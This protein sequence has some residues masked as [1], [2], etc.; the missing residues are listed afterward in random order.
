MEPI[1]DKIHRQEA[2]R[3]KEQACGD[4]SNLVRPVG[5]KPRKKGTRIGIDVEVNRRRGTQCPK[6]GSFLCV[7]REEFETLLQ[8]QPEGCNVGLCSSCGYNIYGKPFA[9]RQDIPERN[10]PCP[11]GS[12]KKYKKC[13][14]TNHQKESPIIKRG[15]VPLKN[16]K[17][18][19]GSGKKYKHCCMNVVEIKR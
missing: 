15:A 11:C 6:C 16:D 14:M 10:D 9:K 12:S 1:A 5:V 17:C 3:M 7:P 8:A 18:P 13:C 19:C 4:M 2:L